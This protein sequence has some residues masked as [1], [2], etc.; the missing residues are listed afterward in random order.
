VVGQKKAAA[1]LQKARH[2]NVPALQDGLVQTA[3]P[4]QEHRLDRHH[5]QALP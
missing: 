4:C 3:Q 5:H 2:S 1:F